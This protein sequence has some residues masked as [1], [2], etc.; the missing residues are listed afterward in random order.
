MHDAELCP[1]FCQPDF[2]E[3]PNP[4]IELAPE[5][6]F[7]PCRKFRTDLRASRQPVTRGARA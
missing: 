6:D 1:E 5:G 4:L 7:E 2:R 3:E